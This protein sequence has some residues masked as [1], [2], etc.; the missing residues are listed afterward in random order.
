MRRSRRSYDFACDVSVV[1]RDDAS[2]M[3]RHTPAATNATKT[4]APMMSS[5]MTARGEPGSFLTQRGAMGVH[6]GCRSE[7]PI[8]DIMSTCEEV[9]REGSP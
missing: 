3:P 1:V 6:L 2:R 7:S 8:S 5:A 9:G 4:I